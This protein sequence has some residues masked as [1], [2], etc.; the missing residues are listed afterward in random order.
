ML[1]VGQ[2]DPSF[3]L[4]NHAGEPVSL[5]NNEGHHDHVLAAL[6]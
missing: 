4:P 2:Q 6:D 1:S 5:S 3:E